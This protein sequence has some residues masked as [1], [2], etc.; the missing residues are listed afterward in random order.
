MTQCEAQRPMLATRCSTW[1]EELRG[2]SNMLGPY[3]PLIPCTSRAPTKRPRLHPPLRALGRMHTH[4][5]DG[6]P[7]ALSQS[8]TCFDGAGGWSAAAL[9]DSTSSS[10][11]CSPPPLAWSSAGSGWQECRGAGECWLQVAGVQGC[12]GAALAA[13]GRGAGVRRRVLTSHSTPSPSRLVA[14][15]GS[16]EQQPSSRDHRREPASPASRNKPASGGRGCNKGCVC[17]FCALCV[18]CTPSCIHVWGLRARACAFLAPAAPPG[19]IPTLAEM[20]ARTSCRVL[21][22]ISHEQL[23]RLQAAR[24]GHN[25]FAACRAAN[26]QLAQVN[27]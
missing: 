10:A 2:N 7:G 9:S 8:N 3:V 16:V 17:V 4:W 20:S 12:R 27:K 22:H 5:Q 18:P 25:D 26:T 21:W 23:E 11:T 14:A 19:F 15:G 1:Q 6:R 13:G 24:A